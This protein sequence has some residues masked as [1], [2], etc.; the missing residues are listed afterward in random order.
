MPSKVS[1]LHLCSNMHE[2]P[3]PAGYLTLGEAPELLRNMQ[4]KQHNSMCA[5]SNVI[6][7][8]DGCMLAVGAQV[9]VLCSK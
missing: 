3:G 1:L 5:G 4:R 2:V 6:T 8:C 9:T 7:V